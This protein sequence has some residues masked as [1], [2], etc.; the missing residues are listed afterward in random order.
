MN[1]FNIDSP[2]MKALGYVTDLAILNIMWLICS[3][4]I[5]TIGASTTALYT[6]FMTHDTESSYVKKFFKSFWSNLKKSTILWIVEFPILLLIVVNVWFYYNHVGADFSIARIL[7]LIPAVLLGAGIEYIFPLQAYF[8]NHI[9]QTLKNSFLI[10]A[11]HFPV[12]FCIL[13]IQVSPVVLAFWNLDLFF[14]I[15]PLLLFWGKA[16]ITN[17]SAILFKRV[18]DTYIE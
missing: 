18:F 10:S 1:F 3:I 15:F 17:V 2:L 7:L 13:A 6:C 16:V 5:V 12:S 14:R 8:E 9:K 4:P 11:A